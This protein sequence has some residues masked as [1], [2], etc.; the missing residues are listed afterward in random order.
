MPTNLKQGE[1]KGGAYDF[2]SWVA[3]SIPESCNGG[4]EGRI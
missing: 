3:D 1:R 2:A 4:L